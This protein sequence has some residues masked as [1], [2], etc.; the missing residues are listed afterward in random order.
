M[1][2]LLKGTMSFIKAHHS[3]AAP[4]ISGSLAFTQASA[5]DKRKIGYNREVYS[6]GGWT[7][8]VGHAATAKIFEE[9]NAS[10]N[11]GKIQ[12]TGRSQDGVI[13]EDSYNYTP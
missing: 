4:F 3:D 6:G 5:S 10:Y 11:N 1:T 12:W 9:I 2:D 13:N 7:V 8:T